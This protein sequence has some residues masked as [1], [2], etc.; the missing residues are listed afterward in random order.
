MRIRVLLH[1]PVAAAILAGAALPCTGPCSLPSCPATD[2]HVCHHAD[3]TTHITMHD[4]WGQTFEVSVRNGS[5]EQ[6]GCGTAQ[7]QPTSGQT[8][9][10]VDACAEISGYCI[11]NP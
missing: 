9:G 6:V 8:W 3:G 2:I 4:P 7:F 5:T 1:S 10:S 11:Y